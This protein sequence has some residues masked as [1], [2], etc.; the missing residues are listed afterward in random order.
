MSA[1]FSVNKTIDIDCG[2]GSMVH[3]T[4]TFYGFSSSG[5]CRLVEG[6]VSAGCTVDDQAHY[7]CVGQRYCSINLPTGQ[8]GVNIP[9]CGQ[10]SNYFQVEYTCVLG[11]YL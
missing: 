1:C 2:A 5:Q 3:I 6:E 7:P 11:E 8:L 4:K 9:T 10:R